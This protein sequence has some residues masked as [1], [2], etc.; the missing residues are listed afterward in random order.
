MASVVFARTA[1]HAIQEHHDNRLTSGPQEALIFLVAGLRCMH[2]SCLR[3]VQPV[4]RFGCSCGLM[5]CRPPPGNSRGKWLREWLPRRQ[6]IMC[7]E[8]P[9]PLIALHHSTERLANQQVLWFVDNLGA[10]SSL[11]RGSARPEDVGHI[12]SMQATFPAQ[13]STRVW[14]E[15]EDSASNPSDESSRVGVDCPLCKRHGWSAQEV[16]PDWDSLYS[17]YGRPYFSV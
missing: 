6:Q 2:P 8:A 12:A 4:R 5:E 7:A 15:W 11:V 17:Q 3:F 9:A 16:V 10:M 13:L 14:Y 1:K